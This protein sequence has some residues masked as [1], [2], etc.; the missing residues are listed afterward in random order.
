MLAQPQR[1]ILRPKRRFPRA[2]LRWMRTWPWRS[3]IGFGV[4]AG[5]LCLAILWGVL[6]LGG[7]QSTPP[8]TGDAR[9]PFPFSLPSQPRAHDDPFFEALKLVVA[10]VLAWV[11]TLV[12]KRYHGGRPLN[13]ALAQAQ[14]LMCVA[15]A[16]MMIIIGN[17]V[18]RAL[19]VAGGASL[20]RFR[21]PVEDPKDATIL[22]L[23]LGLGMSCGLGSFGVA[24]LGAVFL[25]LMLVALDRLEEE[26]PRNMILEVVAVGPIFPVE[27]VNTVLG[28]VVYNYEPR[29]VIEGKEAAR[30]YLVTLSPTSSLAYL[31]QELMKDGT[32]GIKTVSWAHPKKSE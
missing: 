21:T 26:K 32:A 27:H 23:L 28:G 10:A 3:T 8:A 31:S 9:L 14:I 7:Q 6:P 13:R 4:V 25:C 12:H 18:A 11:V 15:A 22:F 16:L 5:L 29:E 2:P 1:A 19:G 24:G 20:V 17:D 30:K